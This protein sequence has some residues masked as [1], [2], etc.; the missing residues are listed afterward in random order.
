MREVN[1]YFQRKGRDGAHRPAEHALWDGILGG[2]DCILAGD[3]NAHSI[4]WNQHC[5]TRR[6]A[7]SL[8]DLITAH[9]LQ[10]LNDDR[11]TIPARPGSDLHSIIDHTL[12]TP[13][14]GP[15]CAEWQVV[16][17]EECTIH[18]FFLG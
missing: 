7:A 17:D 8:E 2:G 14:G 16:E 1:A 4:V 9:E 6:D 10:I 3:F 18:S 13:G 11:A 12:T 15:M 5:T